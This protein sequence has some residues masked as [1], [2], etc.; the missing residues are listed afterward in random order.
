MKF[1]ISLEITMK[2]CLVKSWITQKKQ[3]IS[4]T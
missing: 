2:T 1:R 3:K 4:Q